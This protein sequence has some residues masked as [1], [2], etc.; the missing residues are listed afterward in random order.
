MAERI[1]KPYEFNLDLRSSDIRSIPDMIF[2][3]GDSNVYPIYISLLDDNM[4][5][6]I[7]Q[8]AEVTVVCS[9]PNIDIPFEDFAEIIDYETGKIKYNIK[10]DEITVPG[11]V[12]CLV[13]VLTEDQK[14]TWQ[15]Q[16]H[17]TVKTN[18]A[19]KGS[20]LP[21]GLKNILDKLIQMF[22]DVK[23]LVQD[24]IDTTFDRDTINQLDADTLVSAKEYTDEQIDT[25]VENRTTA[26]ENVNNS[27]NIKI[28]TEAQSREIADNLL[29]DKI[30]QESTVR[31]EEI[32]T[33]TNS[34]D[35]HMNNEILH[36]TQQERTNWN[37]KVDTTYVENIQI[38]LQTDINT[39]A[40][41]ILA[42][43]EATAQLQ[44]ENDSNP[45]NF[46][47]F[48]EE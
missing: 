23:N 13:S 32:S 24:V 28:E 45:N 15:S 2:V 14:L 46:Y 25:E 35:N 6:T 30:I 22:V 36:I 43:D 16:F 9:I 37:N 47:F 20:N 41:F 3:Q 39:K 11:R 26:I 42:T 38:Q 27:V 4:P 29:N 40:K 12:V 10:G 8:G 33:L 1:Y 5:V 18:P 48:V 17:F 44:S 31:E 21:S 7:P 34:L 19:F